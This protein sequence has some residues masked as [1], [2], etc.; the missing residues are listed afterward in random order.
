MA[1]DPAAVSSPSRT[2]RA[3]LWDLDGTLYHQAPMRRRM[4][5]E[6]ARAPLLEG[7]G[8]RRTLRRLK[9]FRRVR[10][11]LRERGRCEEPLE[12]LQYEEPAR[13]LGDDAGALERTV[14]E[15][16]HRKPLRHLEHCRRA[17]LRALLAQLAEH[18]LHLGVFSDYPADAKLIA[19]GLDEFFGLTLC[20][21]DSEV[22]AFKP[23]PRG[24]LRAC[25]L[26]EVEPGEVLY[27]GDR[28]DV[29]GAGARAA[30]MP[31]CIV[32]QD[33]AAL[34]RVRLAAL[35]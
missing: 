5:L 25:E 27:V 7:F 32:G 10:E 29:D 16:M 13:R 11:E 9:T 33:T 28:D 30:G 31:V 35:S 22:N 17:G 2:L 1:V 24:F 23:H 6:L 19:L 4:L 34:D 21:T 14:A 15:W 20:A 26:W 12:R 8:A 18:G 3:V